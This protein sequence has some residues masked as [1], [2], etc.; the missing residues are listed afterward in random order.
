MLTHSFNN[1]L[2]TIQ[3]NKS[4]MTVLSTVSNKQVNFII[5]VIS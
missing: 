3:D 1:F 4:N 2:K 5:G